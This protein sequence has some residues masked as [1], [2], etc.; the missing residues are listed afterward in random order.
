MFGFW[1]GAVS[2]TMLCASRYF[3]YFVFID[4][5]K[6]AYILVMQLQLCKC[7]LSDDWTSVL[8]VGGIGV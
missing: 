3:I 2:I 7:S 6:Y 1:L 8:A 5:G 4:L